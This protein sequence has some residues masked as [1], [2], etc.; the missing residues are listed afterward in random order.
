MVALIDAHTQLFGIFGHP[1]R[2][3]LSPI[4]HNAAFRARGLNAVY[5]AFDVTD[6]PRAVQGVRALGISGLSIT[7]PHK[8]AVMPLLDQVDFQAL[9]IGAV[10]TIV[11]QEGMLLGYNTDCIG[12]QRALEE[13]FTNDQAHL[14]KANGAG[15]S[16]VLSGKSAVILGAGGSAKAVAFGL[17]SAGMFVH[18]ANRTVEKAK[19]LGEALGATFSSLNEVCDITAD[20]LVNT[21]PVGMAPDIYKMPIASEC[22]KNFSVVMDIVYAPLVTALL[23]EAEAAGCRTVNGLRM[24]LHQAVCQ[25]ELWTGLQAPLNVMERALLDQIK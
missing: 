9:Q 3:S 10:N 1:V 7:I 24:L 5:L 15:P 20:V 18:V 12:A 14:A 13:A 11:N 4:L 23:R 2:H 19:A 17:K 21:T 25:F 16:S 8:E 22:L 6:L